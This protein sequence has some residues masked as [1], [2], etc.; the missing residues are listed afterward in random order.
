[1]KKVYETTTENGSKIRFVY[2]DKPY[3]HVEIYRNDEYWGSPQGDIFIKALLKD[4]EKLN[5]K[6]VIKE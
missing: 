4:I 3:S 2:E 1:M 6:D 5:Y